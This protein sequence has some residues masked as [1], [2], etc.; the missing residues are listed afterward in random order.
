[1]AA[2]TRRSRWRGDG[3]VAAW[4]CG[5]AARRLVSRLRGQRQALM[6]LS[7][8][9]EQHARSGADV[10]A[11]EKVLLGVEYG[12]LGARSESLSP[13]MRAVVQRPCR[14]PDQPRGRAP[15]RHPGNTVKTRLRRAK[16]RLR[17]DL[18]A[19]P[20]KDMAT[21]DAG[22][23]GRRRRSAR[24]DLHG[25]A[26]ARGQLARGA[27]DALRR[28]AAPDRGRSST[29]LRCADVWTRLRSSRPGPAPR[30]PDTGSPPRLGVVRIA[31]RCWDRRSPPSL[32]ASA[33]CSESLA[34][35]GFVALATSF[36]SQSGTAFFLLV[37]PLVPVSGVAFAYG[38]DVD[39]AYESHRGG[40]VPGRPAAAAP[41]RHSARD[42]AALGRWRRNW[43]CQGWPW[44][45]LTSW[46]LTGGGLHGR[47]W[48]W[49][50]PP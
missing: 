16:A 7:L 39:P 37:A 30:H 21:S 3:E 13:E 34:A 43:S 49:P 48:G 36:G 9:A 11:E 24:P 23:A 25:D 31:M 6:V 32:R 12:D 8:D 33:G 5:I 15:A 47:C 40:A 20:A 10:S 18:A 17:Q 19:A 50:P 22:P 46:L 44:T 14:R 4:L 27:P 41:H 26:G 28:P 45:P 38:P 2:W 1:M 29:R 35:L 42:L